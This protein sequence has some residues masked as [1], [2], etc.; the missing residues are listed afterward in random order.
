M[1]RAL[2]SRVFLSWTKHSLCLVEKST[3]V[4]KIN[5]AAFWCAYCV[6]NPKIGYSD[7]SQIRT[8]LAFHLGCRY[9]QASLYMYIP[10]A[11]RS[12]SIFCTIFAQ[13]PHCGRR[14]DFPYKYGKYGRSAALEGGRCPS[15][16][17]PCSKAFKTSKAIVL[18]MPAPRSKSL[19]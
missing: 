11:D 12:Y 17:C 4:P 10:V 8:F 16:L 3:I 7:R 9:N 2:G 6:G 13:I 14:S 19:L 18:Q 15:P 1:P 5:F